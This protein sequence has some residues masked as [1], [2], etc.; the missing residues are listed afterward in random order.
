ML[1][2]ASPLR[3]LCSSDIDHSVTGNNTAGDE[4]KLHTFLQGPEPHSGAVLPTSSCRVSAS[5][6]TWC[7]SVIC[8]AAGK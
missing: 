5:F 3:C 8:D 1:L 2:V 6:G 7:P 4:P